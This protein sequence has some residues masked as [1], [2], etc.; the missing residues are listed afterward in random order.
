MYLHQGL[1]DNIVLLLQGYND[2]DPLCIYSSF[3]Y[4]IKDRILDKFYRD[5]TS[6]WCKYIKTP[7]TITKLRYQFVY[8]NISSDY[9]R[10]WNYIIGPKHFNMMTISIEY[11]YFEI[12]KRC[13]ENGIK[14]NQDTLD[15]CFYNGRSEMIDICISHGLTPNLNTLHNI[16][17]Y[18]NKNTDMF[19][20]LV[21]KYNIKPDIII[22]NKLLEMKYFDLFE[23]CIKYGVIPDDTTLYM[24]IRHNSIKSTQ[25]CLD[26]VLILQNGYIYI[27]IINSYIEMFDFLIENGI[28]CTHEVMMYTIIQNNVILFKRCIDLGCKPNK[29]TLEYAYKYR[30]FEIIPLIKKYMK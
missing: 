16:V 21:T 4:R 25:I 2:N 10:Y 3:V 29:S 7:N 9:R 6:E 13:I 8:S 17:S 14:L 12:F 30:C 26:H 18:E 28:K 15:I 19:N 22:M 20:L 1:V 5:S 27:T 24:S 23:I 11:N